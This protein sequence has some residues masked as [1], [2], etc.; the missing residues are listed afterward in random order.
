MKS[1]KSNI[2]S[3]S[4]LIEEMDNYC[5]YR[6]QSVSDLP[7]KPKLLRESTLEHLRNVYNL[8]D[9]VKIQE[10]LIQRLRRYTPSHHFNFSGK[11][12]NEDFGNFLCLAQHHGLPTLLLDWSKNPLVA[13]YFAVNNDNNK[14]GEIWIMKLKDKQHRADMTIHLESGEEFPLD[15]CGPLLIVPK[16]FDT[17]FTA[18]SGRFSYYSNSDSLNDIK[19]E[20]PWENLTRYLIPLKSKPQILKKLQCMQ[21]HEGTLFPDID[22]YAR[23]LT[24]GGL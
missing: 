20:V 6:G 4:E 5:Y 3:V 2:N 17:R 19:G 10:K 24:G 16:P 15:N 13:L 8:K 22:G 11:S 14:D 1:H 12:N 7:L 18:Q 9:P 23:Y 21:I